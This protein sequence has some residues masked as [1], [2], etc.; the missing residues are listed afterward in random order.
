MIGRIVVPKIT[1]IISTKNEY[2]NLS[3]LPHQLFDLQKSFYFIYP[4]E[5][6]LFLLGMDR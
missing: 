5:L 3:L 1:K 2:L 4:K 6:E